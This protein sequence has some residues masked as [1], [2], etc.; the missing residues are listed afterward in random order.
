MSQVTNVPPLM[1]L[2]IWDWDQRTAIFKTGNGE[3]GNGNGEWE[4]GMGTGN[5]RGMT[6]ESAGNLR[7]MTGESA[8]NDRGIC[9][10]FVFRYY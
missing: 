10:E 8:G 7:G 2:R 1:S 3:S 4:R 6:G 5:L 9:G